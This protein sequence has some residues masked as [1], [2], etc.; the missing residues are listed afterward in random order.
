MVIQE[1]LLDIE[2]KTILFIHIIVGIVVKD[3]WIYKFQVRAVNVALFI[4]FWFLICLLIIQQFFLLLPFNHLGLKWFIS[5]LMT[6]SIMIMRYI[7]IYRYSAKE[8]KDRRPFFSWKKFK[9]GEAGGELL[10]EQG[11]IIPGEVGL[12]KG[13]EGL[14]KKFIKEKAEFGVPFITYFGLFMAPLLISALLLHFAFWIP[15]GNVTRPWFKYSFW[16]QWAVM[17]TWVVLVFIYIVVIVILY[18]QW[19]VGNIYKLTKLGPRKKSE[20]ETNFYWRAFWYIFWV[21]ISFLIFLAP[22]T[23]IWIVASINHDWVFDTFSQNYL[24]I[25]IYGGC[26]LVFF[27]IS[28]ILALISYVMDSGVD[29]LGKSLKE[30]QFGLD[31][32]SK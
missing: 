2:F 22:I 12:E 21:F 3:F 7:F 8:A 23:I 32:A 18:V 24:E 16:V 30:T 17:F 6:L 29:E 9:V 26:A 14:T 4:S 20:E 11:D 25:M 31:I 19:L 5:V 27:T 1:P 13:V 10:P 28:L 15:E